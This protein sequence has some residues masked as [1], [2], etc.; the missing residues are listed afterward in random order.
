MACVKKYSDLI[1]FTCNLKVISLL[2][3]H[4]FVHCLVNPMVVGSNVAK[5]K[6]GLPKG[7]S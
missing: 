1:I 6:V 7:L 3:T 5:I 2:F 4:I